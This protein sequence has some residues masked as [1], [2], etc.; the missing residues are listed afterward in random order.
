[1]AN[2]EP[3]T[4]R[5]V[6]LAR[7]K[8][9]RVPSEYPETI[10]SWHTE[11]EP[12]Q[13]WFVQRTGGGYRLKNCGH[14]Q[15]LSIRGTQCNS[16][17]YHGSPTTWKIIPQRPG[18]YLIQLEKIDR[19][20]DL[21][22]RGEVY[23]WPA[24]DAEPQKVWKFEKLGRETGEEMGEVK[25]SVSEQPGDDPAADQ[26]KKAPPPLSP[27]AIRDVQIAQ[28]ARQIQSLEQQLSMKDSEL[29]RLQGELEFIRSQES[30]QTTILSE[31]IAQL[32][33]LVERLFE[34]ESR[35]P[36]NAA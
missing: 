6:N 24:N 8:A 11:D 31:R 9:L 25:D 34:Q 7:N 30:S 4:Y 16:Q 35:R 28:Q 15:Y 18:G 29:E 32:E 3:G 36:N 2:V 5:I 26:P 10:S 13:K 12:N 23:I 1:M 21:H 17:A 33:E 27:L 22:D 19:V 20:L 14:G